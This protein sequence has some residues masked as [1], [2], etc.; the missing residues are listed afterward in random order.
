VVG[1]HSDIVGVTVEQVFSL[2]VNVERDRRI[3]SIVEPVNLTCQVGFYVRRRRS[4]SKLVDRH[5]EVLAFKLH[6][7]ALNR[8]LV[9]QLKVFKLSWNGGTVRVPIRAEGFK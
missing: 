1:V 8:V 4:L 6:F 9:V 2:V 3:S 7:R 5:E